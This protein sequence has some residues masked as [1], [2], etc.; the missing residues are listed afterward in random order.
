MLAC[1]CLFAACAG[2]RPVAAPSIR[3]PSSGLNVSWLVVD[4]AL[5]H[6][7]GKEPTARALAAY[8]TEK[9]PFEAGTIRACRENGVRIVAVPT[10]DLDLLRARLMLVGPVQEQW[11]GQ[12]PAWTSIIQGPNWQGTAMLG[13]D[14]GTLSLPAGSMRLLARCWTVPGQPVEGVQTA[15]WLRGGERPMTAAIELHL[16]PQHREATKGS[17]RFAEVLEPRAAPDARDDGLVFD[18]LTLRGTCEKGM[19]YVL[20]PEDPGVMWN[21]TRRPAEGDPTG[22]DSTA[23]P[24]GPPVSGPVFPRLPTV[25]DVLL[26]D[27]AAANKGRKV[28]LILEPRAPE[29]YELGR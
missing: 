19:A 27:V 10:R 18:R 16:S 29:R 22:M 1:C 3:G 21:E 26:T 14:D 8:E 20:V 17:S 2:S 5:A 11:Y 25:G 13:M 24:P 4:D 28:V 7:N 12:I 6:A 9:L 15:P 23:T